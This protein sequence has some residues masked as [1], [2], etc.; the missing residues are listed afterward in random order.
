MFAS[1]PV[2]AAHPLQLSAVRVWCTGARDAVH[3]H[4]G[5]DNSILCVISLLIRVHLGLGQVNT[6]FYILGDMSA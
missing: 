6:Y 3:R 4:G 2:A 1:G 5:V